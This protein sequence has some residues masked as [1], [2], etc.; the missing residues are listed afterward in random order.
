MDLIKDFTETSLAD[1]G[2]SNLDP[3]EVFVAPTMDSLPMPTML[4]VR[5]FHATKASIIRLASKVYE[6]PNCIS[7]HAFFT[8]NYG[9]CETHDE[10]RCE[11]IAEGETGDETT[12]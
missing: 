3:I 12:Y 7:E 11:K 10:V 1:L 9:Y 8:K 5:Y 6:A 2:S 4:E